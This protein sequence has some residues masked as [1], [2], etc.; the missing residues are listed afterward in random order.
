MLKPYHH[1]H[2][3]AMTAQHSPTPLSSSVR[4]NRP[5]FMH[6]HCCFTSTRRVISSRYES[7]DGC[8]PP[9]PSIL[10]SGLFG[11]ASLITD[12]SNDQGPHCLKRCILRVVS[13]F[14]TIDAVIVSCRKFSLLSKRS[15]PFPAIPISSVEA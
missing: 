10:A 5:K 11:F 15:L 4:L 7:T 3:N 6:E 1:H 2:S 13:L 14:R 8:Q 9:T 12:G